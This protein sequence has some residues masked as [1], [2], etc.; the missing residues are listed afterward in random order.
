MFHS[1]TGSYKG[2]SNMLISNIAFVNF[3]GYVTSASRTASVSCSTRNPCYNIAMKNISLAL[4]Q[5]GTV[6]GA[7]GTCTYIADGGVHGMT[8]SGC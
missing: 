2:T 5:N 3:T 4:T 8:G 7:D 6:E 1:Y